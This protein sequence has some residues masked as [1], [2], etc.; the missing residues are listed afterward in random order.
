MALGSWILLHCIKVPFSTLTEPL[1]SFHRISILGNS[2]FSL[3]TRSFWMSVIFIMLSI[4]FIQDKYKI[5]YSARNRRDNENLRN[6]RARA[7]N[8][9]KHQCYHDVTPK[10]N[11]SPVYRHFSGF[12]ILSYNCTR[13]SIQKKWLGSQNCDISYA[14]ELRIVV[15]ARIHAQ[16]RIKPYNLQISKFIYVN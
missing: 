5:L 13:I 3:L 12:E 11:K 15:R 8:S 6:Y 4:V 7:V 14:R 2:D 10:G 9:K 16:A 1:S